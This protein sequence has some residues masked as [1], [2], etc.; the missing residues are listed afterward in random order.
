MASNR[1]CA[2]YAKRGTSACKKCKQKLEKGILRL[3][4]MVPNPFSDGGDDMK[5][6]F[7]A[8]CIFETF[9]RARATTKKIEEPDDIEGWDD[10][11]DEDKAML[12]KAMA[13]IA[14]NAKNS[15]K[16]PSR[17]QKAAQTPKKETPKKNVA[18][19]D[20]ADDKVSASSSS[21][22][23]VD[24][25]HKD[26]A[27]REFRRLCVNVAEEASYLA[28]TKIVSDFL[29]K[30]TDGDGFHGDLYLWVKL[31]L[32]SFVKRVYNL[33]N[34]Q[35]VNHFSQIFDT[36]M[37][38]MVEDLEKGDVAE[39]V[40]TFFEQSTKCPPAAKSK[41]TIQEVDNFLEELTKVTKDDD[42][43][44]VL[45][46]I[47][48]RCTANDLKIIIRLI[49]RD[50]RINAGAK[51][52]LE[53]VHENAYPAFQTSRDLR[54][55]IDRVLKMRGV[56]S[57]SKALSIR[58]S[59]MTP[60]LP[61]LA[62]ACKSVEYAMKKCP[63]GMYAEIKYD[64]ER[65]QVHKSGTDFS[66][67]SRSLKPVLPHKVSHFK[68]F[69]PLAF[70]HGKDIILDSEVLLIDTVTG[71]PLPFGTL[72]VHKKAAF[73]D[74]N[75]C[76]FV[77]DCVHFNGENLMDK[78]MKERRRI[79]E[80]NMTEVPNR[81][82][83]S[84]AK[85]ISHP[86]DLKDMIM[87]VLRQGLEG[88]VLKDSMGLYEPGKR[89]WL[90]VK[91]DYLAEGVMADSAD[92]V[93][94]GAFYGSGNK[95]GIMSVFLMGCYDTTTKKWCT[96]TK[97]HSGHDDKTLDRLQKE[98]DMVK[99]SKDQS[100]VP[101]WLKVTK[102]MIPDLVARDPKNS[103]VWEIV[104][105]EFTKAEVHTAA[106]ISIRFPRV[107]RIRSDK[108]WKEAT[109]LE[110]LRTLFVNSKDYS[111]LPDVLGESSSRNNSPSK[112]RSPNKTTP[113]KLESNQS[114]LH[115]FL[116]NSPARSKD[117]SAPPSASKRKS[118]TRTSESTSSKKARISL[119]FE[120]EKD[121][122][123][124]LPDFFRGL[125]VFV[126]DSFQDCKE[127]CRYVTTYNGTVVNSLHAEEATHVVV[128]NE[129][130]IPNGTRKMAAVVSKKWLTD[131]IKLQKVVSTK[132]Y[133][134]SLGS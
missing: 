18:A 108:T 60:I 91:K 57:L 58:A 28:K 47:T 69:I 6:W 121:A 94:L 97:V 92:L 105:A 46:D 55:V 130:R 112:V 62:E 17:K 71:I 110:E 48:K 127:L 126:D 128:N 85:Y 5:Q 56:P 43:I 12:R 114:T 4:K 9:A 25:N 131:C 86:D 80:K 29:S 118:E 129:N 36:C 125:A 74:A 95:G 16:T 113:T 3:G 7:H 40:Q 22:A 107:T 89:H 84:E 96:V 104:G 124:Q 53:A 1:F 70:P 123:D 63:H 132:N 120:D 51:H 11:T 8:A 101:D 23:V 133:S 75:V 34:K 81:I 134:I 10:L 61:M 45:S 83:F 27:F 87:A 54:E 26:N 31:L 35:L 119:Q 33:Q 122:T 14:E 20:I 44:R 19:R 100:K 117:G 72:G 79:L 106:G 116:S 88:L 90:K 30:G 65:V 41:L 68:D 24:V 15:D 78:P 21:T 77:F 99:I 49:K 2:D 59:L 111:N 39:T 64:G 73:K 82:K 115:P 103:Q 50:L 67:F 76:L 13:D 32:P 52:I 98:L 66:Y 37:E 38:D 93:V 109:S 42:Q 102:T